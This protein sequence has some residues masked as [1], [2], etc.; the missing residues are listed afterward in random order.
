MNTAEPNAKSARES[1]RAAIEREIDAGRHLPIDYRSPHG[2]EQFLRRVS[3]FALVAKV[4]MASPD[5]SCRDALVIIAAA[6]WR[7]AR[8]LGIEDEL[9]FGDRS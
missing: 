7:A 1:F 9:P 3:E 5:F 4:Q 8:E 6:A 2:R